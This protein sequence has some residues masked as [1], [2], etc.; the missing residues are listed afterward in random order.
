MTNSIYDKLDS[1]IG[2]GPG[3][4]SYLG[5]DDF[6][7]V[8]HRNIR[9]A[10]HVK[11][12]VI[13]LPCLLG[14][15]RRIM[16]KLEVDLNLLLTNIEI[17]IFKDKSEWVERHTII[18]EA[19]LP[20]WIQGDSGRVIRIVMDQEK[21]ASMQALQLAVT[22]E[23]V[24][25]ALHR[26]V[27]KPIP[28]WLDEGLAVFCSQNLPAAYTE[29]LKRAVAGNAL[30]SM[31]MLTPPFTRMDRSVQRLAY[32]QSTAMVEYLVS[33]YGWD[34][35]REMLMA[36]KRG[37]SPEHVLK[38]RGLNYYLLEKEWDRWWTQISHNRGDRR[39]R[40]E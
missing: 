6:V 3:K 24:H 39:L 22:H 12:S 19:D 9:L 31:E 30:L 11:N 18:N 28:A 29:E 13:D 33:K 14:T 8:R 25:F 32:A 16:E 23:V 10:Y 15:I 34:L 5:Q 1:I 26:H 38:A 17:E 7:E 4:K 2:D 21:I 35:I 37:E 27:N 20:S 36:C 40:D